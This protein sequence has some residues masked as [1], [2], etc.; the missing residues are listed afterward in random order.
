[1]KPLGVGELYPR[2][3]DNN[4]AGKCAGRSEAAARGTTRTVSLAGLPQ[5]K[6]KWAWRTRYE[7]ATPAKREAAWAAYRGERGLRGEG[8]TGALH[9]GPHARRRARGLT[10]LLAV[11]EAIR[12]HGRWYDCARAPSRLDARRRTDGAPQVDGDSWLLTRGSSGQAA[13]LQFFRFMCHAQRTHANMLVHCY[14]SLVGVNH[15]S[16]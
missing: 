12:R 16:S 11:H 13:N 4:V 5:R 8:A 14:E 10:L 7:R 2:N 15:V 3:T 6:C 1:M 9:D